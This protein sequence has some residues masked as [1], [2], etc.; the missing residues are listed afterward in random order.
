MPKN[1][2]DIFPVNKPIIGMIHLA[3]SGNEDKVKRALEELVIY[4]EEGVDGAIIEDYH[5]SPHDVYTALEQSAKEEF[6]IIRGVNLLHHPV[7]GFR[8]AS[9]C[10][11]KFVQF[12]DVQT[13]NLE[14]ISYNLARKKHPEIAVLGGVRFK[15]TPE[16]NNPLEQ[17]LNEAMARCE[18]I[19]TTGSGTGKETPLDKLE[20]FKKIIGEFP[21]IVGAG[22]TLENV[23]AQLEYAD[24]AIIG[25]Y[26]KPDGNTRMP[27][28]RARV[29]D[30]MGAVKALR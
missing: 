13:D 21:L 7:G 2:K 5:G 24:A 18:A 27:V 8:Y 22:V 14:V 9:D 23:G 30:L 28:E 6:H 29:R 12:D 26:F 15:Y 20:E 11:A 25:S 16:T 10:G 4:Q 17:D 1:F 19:V 3:G